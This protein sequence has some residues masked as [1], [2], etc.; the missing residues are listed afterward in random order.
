MDN[1]FLEKGKK[2]SEELN[3]VYQT[4]VLKLDLQLG[5][6]RTF[7]HYTQLINPTKHL[8]KKNGK[9]QLMPAN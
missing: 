9:S 4:K 2:R 5:E 6:F 1:N 3:Y 7:Q 8:T